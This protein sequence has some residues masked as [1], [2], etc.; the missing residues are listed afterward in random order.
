MSRCLPSSVALLLSLLLLAGSPAAV[1]A[2]D[3]TIYTENSPPA[4]FEQDGHLTGSSTEMVLEMLKRSGLT[5]EITVAPWPRGYR[6]TQ[7]E[8]DTALFSTTRTPERE[9]LFQWI[10]PLLRITW[11]FFTLRDSNLTITSL[12]DAREVGRI[13]ANR[14]DAKCQFLLQKG[15]RN[16]DPA[17]DIAATMRKLEAGRLDMIISSN[18]AISDYAR[19][20]GVA[21]DSLKPIYQIRQA[22]LYLALSPG[23]RPDIVKRLRQAY[24]A[25][26]KDGT[27]KAIYAR[28][29]PGIEP[30]P[31]TP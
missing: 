2:T 26:R 25:M 17:D 20:A 1:L 29:Y 18:L 31:Q 28:W 14:E 10:G 30:P 16:V 24:A 6:L 15:F 12:D 21:A 5:A 3:L 19:L 11:D 8:P 7:Q 13:G 22:D 23:T 9:D 27:F 4:N